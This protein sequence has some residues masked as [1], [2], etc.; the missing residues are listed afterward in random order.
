MFRAAR[1]VKLLPLWAIVVAGRLIAPGATHWGVL[2][3]ALLGIVASSLFAMHVNVVTDIDLD[4]ASKPKLW[5]WLSRDLGL[6]RRIAMV[7][8]LTTVASIVVLMGLGARTVAALLTIYAVMG[9]LYSYNFVCWSRPRATRLKVYWWGHFG[10]MATIYMCLWLVGFSSGA[11][12]GSTALW[13]GVFALVTLGDYAL[14]VAES[15]GDSEEERAA[16]LSTLGAY[17][18]RPGSQAI[19]AGL[20]ALATAGLIVVPLHSGP[21]QVVLLPGAV[22]STLV[23]AALLV[24]DS[25][26]SRTGRQHVIETAFIGTRVYV[27]CALLLLRAFG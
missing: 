14:F 19:A 25:A 5:E 12:A 21:A 18:G 9:T 17:F 7:E 1:P 20:A 4:R 15:A 27:I 22:V 24:F 11:A 23:N 6:A 2:G 10:T 13:W 26:V 16:R 3:I 8:L